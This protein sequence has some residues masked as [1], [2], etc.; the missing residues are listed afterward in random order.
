MHTSSIRSVGIAVLIGLCAGCGGG[1]SPEEVE[2]ERAKANAEWNAQ[3][4]VA[5]RARAEDEKKLVDQHLAEHERHE[6][7]D[8][9]REIA[10]EVNGDKAEQQ[11]LL[12]L[13]RGKYADPASAKFANVHWNPTKSA[14]CGEVSVPGARGNSRFVPFIVNGDEPIVDSTSEEEHARYAVAA[15]TIACSQ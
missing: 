15:Q 13:V 5:E 3:T 7:A 1:K 9:E 8:E 4:A 14:L 6:R 12:D 11:R 10:A 2:A